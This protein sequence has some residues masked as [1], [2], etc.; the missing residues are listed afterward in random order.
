MTKTFSIILPV[1]N[2]QQ[3]IRRAVD[4]ILN[5]RFRDFEL[6]VVDDGST[7]GSGQILAQ[8][9]SKDNRI[10]VLHKEN[11]GANSARNL[12]LQYVQGEYV[13]F[14]DADDWVEDDW[15]LAFVDNFQ[16]NDV[17]V[18]GWTYVTEIERMPQYY[19]EKPETPAEAADLMSRHESFGF[20]WNK[21]FRASII[22]RNSLTFNEKFHFLEDEEFICRYWT[23]VQKV[24]FVPVASYQYVKPDFEQ[25]YQHIDNYYLYV[26]LLENASKFVSN[27]DSVTMKKYTM[28]VFRCMMLPFENRKYKEGW[29]RLKQV[30]TYSSFYGQYNKYMRLIRPWNCWEWL[31][32]LIVCTFFKRLC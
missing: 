17:V 10:K 30:A 8:Y 15:L 12:A 9:A 32:I 4:S 16:D 1:Y 14:C 23:Y 13:T 28:G 2:A 11:G 31:P 18:Q 26:S 5:Q 22:K 29:Y 27:K 19:V 6:L 25:K 20:L 24:K 7:D 3:T 21:C